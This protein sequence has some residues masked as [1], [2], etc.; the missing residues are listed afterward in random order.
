MTPTGPSRSL[1]LATRVTASA[2]DCDIKPCITVVPMIAVGLN[3]SAAL[4]FYLLFLPVLR[5]KVYV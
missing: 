3:E 4:M 2:K 1:H 5:S